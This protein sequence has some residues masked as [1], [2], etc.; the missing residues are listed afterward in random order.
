MKHILA[1]ASLIAVTAG[2]VMAMSTPA[3][4]LPGTS[5][6]EAERIVPNGNFDNLTAAQVNAIEA[7][8]FS[9]N[10]NRGGQI[11]AILLN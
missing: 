9:D 3:D 2:S 11:R 5:K 10:R 1:V 6:A 7:I 8:L 4:V